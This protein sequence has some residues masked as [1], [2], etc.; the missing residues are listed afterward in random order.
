[1]GSPFLGSIKPSSRTLPCL[2]GLTSAIW[3]ALGTDSAT[4]APLQIEHFRSQ[5]TLQTTESLSKGSN[6]GWSEEEFANATDFF[7][8]YLEN[9][10]ALNNGS[11]ASL[12]IRSS[13][14]TANHIRLS[15]HQQ[16][17]ITGA[18]GSTV[19]LSLQ[20]FHLGG[21]STLLL[22]GDASSTFIIN[23]TKGFSLLQTSKIVLS[24]GV[25]WN[26]VFFNVLGVGRTV[27]TSGKSTLAGTLT[28]PQRVVRLSGHAVVYGN[29][30]ANQIL[31]CQ[32]A[33]IVTPPIVSQ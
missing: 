28:A 18:P 8:S 19:A 16:F 25:Q 21:H 14:S 29:V 31:F 1:M 23:V 20:G 5:L 22:A 11:G 15:G 10:S 27:V 13:A 3:T 6:V 24:P 9:I 7:S 30:F 2:L 12:A 4:A 26:Q 32:A 33:Q 17:T